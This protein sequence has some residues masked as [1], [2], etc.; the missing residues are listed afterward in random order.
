[1]YLIKMMEE[2]VL[3]Q[4]ESENSCPLYNLS[5]PT[6]TELLL[7]TPH[8]V[9]PL[10]LWP[11]GFLSSPSLAEPTLQ[12]PAHIS[13]SLCSMCFWQAQPKLILLY[14]WE[15][16]YK[17]KLTYQTEVMKNVLLMLLI[18]SKHM[19]IWQQREIST[20]SL[21][22]FPISRESDLSLN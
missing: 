15:P 6:S 21:E 16:L 19:K 13:I 18:K 11:C 5:S 14:I 4:K 8:T 12:I 7:F 10:H 1:M 3:S 22:N 17:L 2:N 9:P 20:A